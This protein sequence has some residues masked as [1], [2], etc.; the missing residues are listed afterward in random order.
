VTAVDSS[1]GFPERPSLSTPRRLLSPEFLAAERERLARQPGLGLAGLLLVAPVAI[2][3]AYAID[4]PEE[5]LLILAPLSTFAL[6]AVAMIGFWWN[7]WPGSALRAPWTG[8]ADTLLVLAAA[9]LLTVLGQAVVGRV[10]LAG[11]FDATPG[12]GTPSTFPATMPLAAAAFVAMLELTLVSEG[13]PLRRFPRI[14]SGLAA[15]ALAWAAALVAYLL[16]VDSH[17]PPGQGLH[18]R[19]GPVSGAAFGAWLVSLGLWQVCFFVVL[20][21]WPFAAIRRRWVRLLAGNFVVIGGG[22]LTYLALRDLADWHP[23]TNSA[24]GG[25]AIAA[26][27]LVGMLFEGWPATNLSPLPGRLLKFLGI[28]LLTVGLYLGLKALADGV[29]WTKGEPEDWVAYVGL[30]GIGAGII[31]HVAIG[32]R[33][34]FGRESDLVPPQPSS[35]RL[36]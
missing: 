29:D 24:V 17:A 12:P 32:K 25:V 21:G 22:W 18:D 6:P 3:L 2:L 36:E 1:P 35:A 10:D 33:W 16:L 31:L 5:S 7:D 27:L 20:H 19:S 14:P 15:L 9:V 30:N 26:A 13:W 4:G 34:P 11:I 8:L 28:A 23:A